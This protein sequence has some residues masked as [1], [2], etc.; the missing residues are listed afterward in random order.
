MKIIFS[1]NKIVDIILFSTDLS[2]TYQKIYRHLSHLPVPFRPWDSPYYKST[3]TRENLVNELMFYANIVSVKVDQQLCQDQIYLNSLHKIYEERYDGNPAWLDFHEHIHLCEKTHAEWA[4]VMTIDYR[5]KSGMLEK[6]VDFDWITPI[7]TKIKA[8]DVYVQ[9]SELGK[10]PYVYWATQEPDDIARICA[11]SKPWLKLRPKIIVALEDIDFL[12]GIKVKEFE[13]WWASY[14]NQWCQHWNI[15][16]WTIDY[17]F[18]VSVFGKVPNFATIDS[19][20]QNNV[21]PTRV[22]L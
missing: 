20:L 10:N 5:E 13:N 15:P 6:P 16:N 19:Q 14:S 17:I 3:M 1:D 4:K 18:G 12:K 8:G 7:S 22:L 21:Y 9:W 2:A 11:L